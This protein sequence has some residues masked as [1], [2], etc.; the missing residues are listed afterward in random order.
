MKRTTLAQRIRGAREAKGYTQAEAD[1]KAGLCY[2]SISH[3]ECG[4]RV[5]RLKALRAIAK[6]LGVPLAYLAGEDD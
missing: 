3:Y 6:A 4:N 1:W 5:P 2:G